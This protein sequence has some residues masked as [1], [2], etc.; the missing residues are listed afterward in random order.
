MARALTVAARV[1]PGWRLGGAAFLLAV[2]LVVSI[3]FLR[4]ST[5]GWQATTAALLAAAFAAVA[6]RGRASVRRR[7]GYLTP[8][9][10]PPPPRLFFGR[11]AEVERIEQHLADGSRARRVV[12]IQGPAGI[13]K[14]TLALHMAHRV[15]GSFPAGQLFARATLGR[16]GKGQPHDEHVDQVANDILGSFITSLQAADGR[17]PGGLEPR[18]RRF[19]E[20][21]KKR[22]V[23]VVLDDAD[24]PALVRRL[25]P[26]G[27]RCAA[28]VT[29]RTAPEPEPGPAQSIGATL[30]IVLGGLTEADT[31]EMV[32]RIVGAERVARDPVATR[33]I[34]A[35]TDQHPLSIRL[36]ATALAASPYTSLG[37]S[38]TRMRAATRRRRK[39][40]YAQALDLSYSLLTKDEQHALRMIGLLEQ[41]RFPA[42]MLAVLMDVDEGKA[43]RVADRL[44]Y[45]GLLNRTRDESSGLATFSVPEHLLAYARSRRN[46]ESTEPR[47]RELLQRLRSERDERKGSGP[48]PEELDQRV[49]VRLQAGEIFTALSAARELLA[50][51]HD[52]GDPDSGVLARAVFAEVRA[53][54]GSFGAATDLAYAVIEDRA[55]L[56]GARA[57]ALR[58]LGRLHRSHRQVEGA[59]QRLRQALSAARAAED[60]AEQVRVLSEL[61]IAQSLG[62]IPHRAVLT[63]ERAVRMCRRSGRKRE[64]VGAYLAG[65]IAQLAAGDT[66]E[67]GSLLARARDA[68]TSQQQ[69]LVQAWLSYQEA[70]LLL[71]QG[72]PSPARKAASAGMKQFARMNHRY[73]RAYCRLVFGESYLAD[74]RAAD[75]VRVLAEALENF[76][77]CG[78][79]W[80]EGEA[81]RL[82]GEAYRGSGQRE[83]AIRT[84]L[85][86]ADKF[87]DVSDLG[88]MRRVLD[89]VE[90]IEE[91][92]DPPPPH[93]S[94]DGPDLLAARG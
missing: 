69:Q 46:E 88:R 32:R 71:K 51:A 90:E 31:L 14:T 40:P 16:A 42:W 11:G 50:Q 73:G 24:D 56:P 60:S 64:L 49:C 23:L 75:A 3:A 68:A 2:V 82:L 85:T 67:A 43:A 12:L 63:A 27:T 9:E 81:A 83:Y 13:G 91:S 57:R 35:A 37:D 44:V 80:A 53:E 92:A 21:T 33:E 38:V 94:G 1:L 76:G 93:S 26:A 86:A 30:P 36:A 20:L 4:S 74:N 22:Q 72:E 39:V 77:S 54:L 66:A 41:P 78:D 59:E 17:L 47:R 8:M 29:S 89:R 10:L 19:R 70:V 18:I 52:A 25:L 6:W 61:A 45:F 34:V 65:S 87:D 15:A 79:R 5:L 62:R 48:T 58:C 7:R 55:A 28:I 84:L